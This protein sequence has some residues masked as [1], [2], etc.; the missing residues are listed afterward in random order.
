MAA[1][2]RAE[3]IEFKGPDASAFADAQFA[4]DVAGLAPS[5]WQWSAW[6][7][8]QGRVRAVFALL[9]VAPD[10]L[11]AWLPLGDASAT[12]EALAR[13]V[14]RS[15]TTLA[16]VDGWILARLDAD[17]LADEAAR[18]VSSHRHGFALAM[19]GAVPRCA[20]LGPAS[21]HAFDT[22]ARAA[23]RLADIRAGLP[24]IA[25]ATADEFVPQA[26]GLERLDAVRFDKGCYPGQEIAARLHFRGG[27]KRGLH[28]VAFESATDAAPGLRIDGESGA[29][30]VLLY[31]AQVDVRRREALA[32]L[33]E[34]FD[35]RTLR[36]ADGDALAIVSSFV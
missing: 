15:K 34:G 23:W 30:G 19:P 5:T 32:V 36:T 10:R 9:R 4:S 25:P 29:A 28:R 31:G 24:F 21:D 20:W 8:A 14:F 35:E 13:F 18:T 12:R 1:R 17:P 22:G 26:L 3:L 27:N 6:L 7:S 2:E 11:L 16:T 33:G